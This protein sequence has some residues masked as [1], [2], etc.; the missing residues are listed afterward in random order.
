MDQTT[1]DAAPKDHTIGRYLSSI[2]DK[3]LPNS[4]GKVAD[5][6]P[7]L[8]ANNPDQF[9]VAVAT[10]GGQLWSYG[11]AGVEFTMQ[12][13]SKAFSYCLALELVGREQVLARVGVEPS[14][15]AFNAIIFDPHTNRPFNPMV[16]AGAITI[17]SLIHKKL[18]DG[19]M[20]FLLQR[21]SEAAGRDLKIS[22]AVYGS[23]ARTG[24]RNRA[25][26]H[27][28][29]NVGATEAPV[30]PGTRFIFSPVFGTGHRC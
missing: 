8:A 22:E 13:V 4:N 26:A 30:E 6:I 1:G 25:I 19:A 2:Y 29:L 7:E 21:F 23:E 14:G 15:D 20:D 10:V 16:N 24:H 5:Y 18:G 17:S 12:S 11:D 9:G 27:L 28:L 3:C